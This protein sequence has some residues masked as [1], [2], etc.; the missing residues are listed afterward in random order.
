MSSLVRFGDELLQDRFRSLMQLER[1]YGMPAK[2]KQ[3][4]AQR[5]FFALRILHNQPVRLQSLEQ[6]MRRAFMKMIVLADFRDTEF[7][8]AI[9]KTILKWS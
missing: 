7:C 3:S 1:R 8:P 5:V 2:L 4:Q 9:P 6:S